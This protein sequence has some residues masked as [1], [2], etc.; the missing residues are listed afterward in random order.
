MLNFYVNNKNVCVNVFRSGTE[1]PS[2]FH[3][4]VAVSDVPLVKDDVK[5]IQLHFGFDELG[6]Q[7]FRSIL[8]LGKYISKW[9]CE[10]GPKAKKALKIS[11]S[12]PA[13]IKNTALFY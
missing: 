10:V 7:S 12:S 5:E 4:F 1:H 3:E 8:T 11:E 9:S 13:V 6:F 2:T